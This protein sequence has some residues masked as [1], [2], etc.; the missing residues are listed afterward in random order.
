MADPLSIAGSLDHLSIV[1][2]HSVLTLSKLES[3]VCQQDGL[4]SQMRW[5]LWHEK[6][7]LA[8]LPR[9]E[10]QKSTLAVM[11][12]ILNSET[13]EE[14]IRSQVTL[15]AKVDEI[16]E[17]NRTLAEQ[18]KLLGSETSW[19][20][21][22]VKFMDNAS[23][24]MSRPVSTQSVIYRS[25][26]AVFRRPGYLEGPMIMT[27]SKRNFELDL[28]Q[29]RVY[30][31][32]QDRET[33][34]SSFTTSNAPTSAWSMLS[35][36]SIGDISIVSAFRLP[37]TLKE[38]NKIAPGSI[39]SGLLMDHQSMEDQTRP[40]ASERS[41]SRSRAPSKGEKSA[42]T[43]A[44]ESDD[45]DDSNDVAYR[46]P[47]IQHEGLKS[48]TIMIVGNSKALKSEMINTFINP[49]KWFESS[50]EKDVHIPKR[51]HYSRNT[52]RQCAL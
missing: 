15:L 13:Q 41:D 52:V 5:A 16:L 46:E 27:L 22:S 33:D 25:A 34:R 19:D 6:K 37:I 42:G 10:S 35:G 45:S 29:S 48:F 43:L 44:F 7:I 32:T 24:I 30:K 47:D 9:L 1:I 36:L 17:Q 26:S 20:T 3:I 39:F 51:A 40:E 2:T 50:S 11:I 12:T 18:L 28:D 8:L 38:I 14:A 4:R 21:R 23:S 49:N 31:R